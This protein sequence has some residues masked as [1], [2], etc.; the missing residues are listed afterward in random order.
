V[1]YLPW[2][3]ML[4]CLLASAL[5]AYLALRGAAISRRALYALTA[6]LAPLVLVGAM[7][8]ALALSVSLPLLPQG[9]PDA[10]K[11]ALEEPSEEARQGPPGPEEIEVPDV[12]GLAVK[13]ARNRLTE[14]GFEVVVRHRE[15]SE[16]EAGMVLGQSVPGAK[17]AQKGSK[18]LLTVGEGPQ[19]PQ[20]ARIPNLVGL[21]YPD[22]ENKL[23]EAG[24]LLGGVQE[25]PS[26]T[27]PAGAIMKQDPPSGT[28]LE[29][30]SY[31]YLTTSVGLS[32]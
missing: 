19:G 4:A 11:G 26:D 13:E 28:P 9:V 22:A 20:V 3:G 32:P 30:N 2:W 6:V 21:S 18:I 16:E 17:E 15:G 24:F 25:A 27:V 5:A 7:V 29:P 8:A 12:E 10:L 31:V 14:A 1:Y 23:E